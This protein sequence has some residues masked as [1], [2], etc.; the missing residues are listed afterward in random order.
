MWTENILKKVLFGNDE[1]RKSCDFSARDIFKHKSKMTRDCSVVKFLR[2]VYAGP[3]SIFASS[4]VPDYES[5]PYS[6]SRMHI[7][8]CGL[9]CGRTLTYRALTG[10]NLFS[11]GVK[12]SQ[13][14][15]NTCEKIEVKKLGNSNSD[16]SRT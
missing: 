12:W 7:Q 6:S 13:F 1:V 5:Q 15:V 16:L 3:W 14:P 11:T 4:T 2:V 8:A 10:L 9:S